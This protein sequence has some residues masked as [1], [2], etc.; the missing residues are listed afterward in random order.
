MHS[1][2]SFTFPFHSLSPFTHSPLS[3]FLFFIHS[4]LSFT[5]LLHRF[6]SFTHS[7]LLFTLSHIHSLS[8]FTQYSLSFTHDSHSPLLFNFL[9]YSL[10]SVIHHK[11]DAKQLQ[12]VIHHMYNQN[13]YS[14]D[15][16][17]ST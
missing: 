1:T 6:S 3:L 4:P 7:P 2:L 15:F 16:M 10:D 13:F 17:K 8:S 11:T 12:F 9:F 14:E 5:L